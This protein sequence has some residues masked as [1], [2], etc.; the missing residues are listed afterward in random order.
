MPNKYK[1]FVYG[2]LKKGFSNHHVLSGSTF[3]R[4]DKTLLPDFHMFS[5]G[6]FPGV[7]LGKCYISGELY[8]VNDEGLKR[9]DVLESNGSFY[10]REVVE[11]EG[12]ENAWMYLLPQ[13]QYEDETNEH[14][15]ADGG[16]HSWTH[17]L[18]VEEEIPTPQGLLDEEDDVPEEETTEDGP[19]V[20]TAS[21][22]MFFNPGEAI[23]PPRYNFDWMRN[24]PRPGVMGNNVVDNN[25]QP[26]AV[27]PPVVEEG[28]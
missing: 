13:R 17:P 9:L 8:E 11:M 12:G 4:E 3:L 21:D 18:E 28:T 20:R 25:P 19:R 16:I 26:D 24:G 7:V 14:V 23:A 22:S 27:D 2:S 10:T 5:M 6:G 15:L 1:A